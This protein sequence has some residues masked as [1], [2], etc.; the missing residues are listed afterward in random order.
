MSDYSEDDYFDLTDDGDAYEQELLAQTQRVKLQ[1]RQIQQRE[2][3][4]R[5][6][7]HG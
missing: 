1:E 2:D 6:A 7:Q 3:D 5:P 4:Q